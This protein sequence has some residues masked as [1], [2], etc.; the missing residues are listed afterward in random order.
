MLNF[1]LTSSHRSFEKYF[2]TSIL[3]FKNI[4]KRSVKSAILRADFTL[5]IFNLNTKGLIPELLKDNSIAF[6][7]VNNPEK[8][9]IFSIDAPYMYDASNK[10]SNDI[11]LTLEPAGKG[12]TLKIQ[13]NNEW[14]S[15]TDRV[16]PI[17]IDHLHL[18]KRFD[19]NTIRI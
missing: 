2:E 1:G 19:H 4:A 17:V 13:P 10:L 12:Y 14:L 18:R 15:N 16:F 3:L 6:Y 8:K 7:D 5:L 11:V 9:A